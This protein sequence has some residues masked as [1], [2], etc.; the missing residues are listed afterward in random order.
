MRKRHDL[1]DLAAEI[2]RRAG[3]EGGLS[4]VVRV[5]EPVTPLQQLQLMSARLQGRAIVIA[6]VKCVTMEEWCLRY[7]PSAA[8]GKLCASS[9]D[10]V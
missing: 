9:P 6:P 7:A 3:G 1:R 5:S 2:V 8:K 4:Y 10:A